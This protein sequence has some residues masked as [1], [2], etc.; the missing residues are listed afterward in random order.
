VK[1]GGSLA[2]HPQKLRSLCAKLSETS[3]KHRLIVV[4]GGG[5]F[6]D[7]VRNLDKRF[8]LSPAV[9]HR[10]A[11]LGM[12][13]YGLMLSNLI[14]NSRLATT[15]NDLQKTMDS[16]RLTVF[17]PS[18]SLVAEDALKNSWDVTSDSIT[19]FIA[20]KLHSARVILAT[21]VDGVFT[22]DP[23]KFPEA[24]LLR[25]LS[26]AELLRMGD[27]T[28]VDKF[29]PQLLLQSPMECY[30]VSGFYPG[31]V[32]AI[33]NLKETICTQITQ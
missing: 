22:R 19:V 11:I 32:E 23:K 27:R 10:M 26:A 5:E 24:K 13:Q 1:I 33:L 31:R 30:V 2:L 12:D 14:P 16:G 25:K 9:A 3:K 8:S 17:L 4:P 6:A 29:L 18:A 28:S 21:D 20:L 15:L 7:T